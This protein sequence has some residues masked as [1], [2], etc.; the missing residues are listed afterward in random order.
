ML[1]TLVGPIGSGKTL[2]L[3]IIATDS[4]R[5]IFS[6]YVIDLPLYKSLQVID[7]LDLKN[8]INVFIDEAY[9]WLESRTSLST[10]NRYLSYIIYQSRKRTIDIYTTCQMFSSI[11][12]RFREQSNIII[13]CERK[14]D[15]FHY[16]F[17]QVGKNRISRFVLPWKNAKKYFHLYDTLEIIEPNQKQELEFKLLQV[18]PKQLLKK[19]KEIAEIIKPKIKRITHD[20]I[21]ATLLLSGYN[22]S[23]EKYIYLYLKEGL[24]I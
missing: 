9:T 23:Y 19:V 8:N 24:T 2:L 7:L 11:D 17:I 12:I 1:I 20:S 15:N 13:E 21:K 5:E 10:L 6:N 18:Y 14:N 3:T 4:I 16:T 22:T